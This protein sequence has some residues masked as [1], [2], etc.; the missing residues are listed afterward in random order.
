MFPTLCSD[1]D[2]ADPIGRWLPPYLARAG[3]ESLRGRWPWWEKKKTKE[4]DR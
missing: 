1:M 4:T 3:R 2:G